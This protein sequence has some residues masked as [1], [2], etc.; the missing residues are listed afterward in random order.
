MG[1]SVVPRGGRVAAPTITTVLRRAGIAPGAVR[2][3]FSRLVADGWIDREM[4]GRRAFYRLSEQGRAPFAGA[5]AVIYAAPEDAPQHERKAL[6]VLPPG[7]AAPEGATLLR[8]G[9]VLFDRSQTAIANALRELGCIAL[10]LADWNPP[11]WALEAEPFASLDKDCAAVRHRYDVVVPRDDLE[12]L[13][14]RTLLIHDWRRVAL[15]A[16]NVVF[17]GEDAVERCRRF[18]ARR[19]RKWLDPSEAWLDANASELVP[20]E[21]A[22]SRLKRRFVLQS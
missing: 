15:R 1:D 13:V 6:A 21:Q 11:Q 3:A 18:V 12:A 20:S 8:D 7:A 9:T 5:A 19:Y 2:T 17:P 10:D 4:D 22:S 14:Q 16:E